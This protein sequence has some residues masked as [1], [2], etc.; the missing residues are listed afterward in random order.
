MGHCKNP[1][2]L[3]ICAFYFFFLENC[4]LG[5][6]SFIKHVDRVGEGGRGVAK[7]SILLHKLYFVKWSTKE[8]VKNDQKTVHMVYEQPQFMPLFNIM[9]SQGVKVK[10]KMSWVTFFH[11]TESVNLLLYPL[12]VFN[13]KCSD[14]HG[15]P[16]LNLDG[17]LA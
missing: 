1:N 3:P 13:W 8:R 4:Q 9:N 12:S 16:I 2:F 11:A 5:S 7:C 10:T 14:L 17:I 6:F 15:N